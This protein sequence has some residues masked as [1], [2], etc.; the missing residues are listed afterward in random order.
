MNKSIL[1]FL[2]PVLVIFL[3]SLACNIRIPNTQPT[4]T[5]IN[6]PLPTP[7]K[8][9][10]TP[11]PNALGE[12]AT[13]RKPVVNVRKSPNGPAS[14]ATLKAGDK[15]TVLECKDNWCKI[16]TGVLTGYVFRGCLS[17]NEDLG[18]EAK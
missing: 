11:S 14:G 10:P 3:T 1:A 7:T 15:V 8:T 18:C 4:P 17:G 6:T 9:L 16:R 2:T 12:F 5:A 13:V